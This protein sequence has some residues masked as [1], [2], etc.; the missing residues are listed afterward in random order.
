VALED[1]RLPR[2]GGARKAVV[3]GLPAVEKTQQFHDYSQEVVHSLV[4][5]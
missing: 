3:S 5:V 1:P 2:R 4:A